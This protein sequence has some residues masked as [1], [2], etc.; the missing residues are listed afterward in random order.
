MFPRQQPV[1]KP[2]RESITVPEAAA[3]PIQ[4]RSQQEDTP[5]TVF[6]YTT[7]MAQA[8]LWERIIRTARFAARL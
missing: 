2:A 4:L 5:V 1:R 7:I 3:T 8:P 6:G